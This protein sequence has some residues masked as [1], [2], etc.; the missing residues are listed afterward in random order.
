[1]IAIGATD[2]L[3]F[4]GILDDFVSTG[5]FVALAS[6]VC[7]LG[8]LAFAAALEA[9]VSTGL[10]VALLSVPVFDEVSSE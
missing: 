7:V 2:A 9:F 5:T 6:V 4:D 3:T 10:L 8:V 1:M